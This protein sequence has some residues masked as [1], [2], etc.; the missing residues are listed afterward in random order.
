MGHVTV[1]KSTILSSRNLTFIIIIIIL[2][3]EQ[4]QHVA[5]CPVC[6]NC[7]QQVMVKMSPL[8]PGLEQ[9]LHSRTFIIGGYCS[10]GTG[11]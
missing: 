6:P 7:L 5:F 9:N 1:L 8:I 3:L 10:S 2:Y 11:T 4:I